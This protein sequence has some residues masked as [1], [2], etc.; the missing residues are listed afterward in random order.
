MRASTPSCICAAWPIASSDALLRARCAR[1]TLLAVPRTKSQS[2]DSS[3]PPSSNRLRSPALR[4][5][6][7][8]FRYTSP[9]Q[10]RPAVA[11]WSA[12]ASSTGSVRGHRS[13]LGSRGLVSDGSGCA[14]CRRHHASLF[15]K[16]R[17]RRRQRL[18]AEAMAGATGA[19]GWHRRLI[20][21]NA[22]QRRK[23]TAVRLWQPGVDIA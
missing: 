21:R 8:P 12:R 7:V 19:A 11:P 18:S 17:V 10:V 4:L 23:R 16:V 2:Y 13:A 9:P 5:L 20:G 14:V 1:Q 22:F 3:R 15:S 6:T